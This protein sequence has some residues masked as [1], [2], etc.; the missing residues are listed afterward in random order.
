[1]D[2]DTTFL[3]F[4]GLDTVDVG[5]S[6]NSHLLIMTDAEA[7]EHR[8]PL[9]SDPV[10]V[11]RTLPCGVVLPSGSVSRQHCQFRVSG[12]HAEVTDLGST[13]GTF[14]NGQRI[15]R[16][17]IL[18]HGA[19]LQVGSYGFIYECRN[20]RELEQAEAAEEQRQSA[21]RYVQMLLPKPIRQGP[22]RAEW[23]FLPCAR[24]GGNAFGYRWMGSQA[25]AGFMIDVAGHDTEAA[26]HSVAI[27]NMLR[28]QD[29]PGADLLDPASVLAALA[30][31]FPPDDHAGLFFSC[32]Y[33]VFELSSRTLRYASGGRSPAYL[34]RP[35]AEV[36][37]LHT[38]DPAVG[39]GKITGF[40]VQQA[41]ASPGSRLYLVSEGISECL[42]RLN[43][44]GASSPLP[45]L[46]SSGALA[47]IPEPSR[48]HHALQNLMGS[49]RLDDDCAILTCSF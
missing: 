35:D 6:R 27:M 41:T 19:V 5:A 43:S 12:S 33:F 47:E 37:E 7:V 17:T 21:S 32:A 46:I 38:H 13:N 30:R 29:V 16:P 49:R 24:L 20:S 4:P 34:W 11:G 31:A 1:M 15:T 25:F 44:P 22:V 45:E 18:Q 42:D 3:T 8:I 39:L 2:E 9:G 10:L 23:L 14:V 28:Q 48:L 26:M 40:A 36:L